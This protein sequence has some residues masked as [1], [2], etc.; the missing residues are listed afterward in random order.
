MKLKISLSLFCMKENF[1][2]K[3]R[4]KNKKEKQSN[5]WNN[6]HI[7]LYVHIILYLIQICSKSNTLNR[8]FSLTF[9][10][11]I[12]LTE[13]FLWKKKKKKKDLH[14]ILKYWF[15]DY[16]H[17]RQTQ[18]NEITSRKTVCCAFSSSK[19]ECFKKYFL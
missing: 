10:S 16:S 11:N 12:K 15:R 9:M 7:R 19:I 18:V 3:T 4:N 1:I 8:N 5:P 2:L 14:I 17:N 13:K 6:L